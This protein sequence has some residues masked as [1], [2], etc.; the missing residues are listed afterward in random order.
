MPKSIKFKDE[1]SD[2]VYP[3]PF[4]PIGYI[5]I[6]SDSTNP[7]TLGFAGTWERFAKGRVLVGV[8]ENDTDFNTPLK[9]IGSKYLQAHTH[10]QKSALCYN[11]ASTWWIGGTGGTTIQVGNTNTDTTGTGNSGNLQPS[12]SVYMFRRTA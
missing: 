1:Q 8:D 5:Y 12:I 9:T 11:S 4:L 10:N 2:A 3:Y 7:S 6:S